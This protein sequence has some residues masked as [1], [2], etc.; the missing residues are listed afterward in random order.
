MET[1]LIGDSVYEVVLKKTADD[2]EKAGN[3]SAAKIMRESRLEHLYVKKQ[4][5]HQVYFANRGIETGWLYG[6]LIKIPGWKI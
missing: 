4:K 3:L 6:G 1:V 2:Q 5:G